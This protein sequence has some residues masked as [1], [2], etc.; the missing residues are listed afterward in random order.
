[1]RF[2]WCERMGSNLR[3]FMRKFASFPFLFLRTS[4]P[5]LLPS[6]LFLRFCPLFHKVEEVNILRKTIGLKT[7]IVPLDLF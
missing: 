3:A 7:E 4:S 6:C 1:M 2:G 5:H